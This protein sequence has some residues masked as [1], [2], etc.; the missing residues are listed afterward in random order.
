MIC[1]PQDRGRPLIRP[2]LYRI[3]AAAKAEPLVGSFSCVSRRYIRV[4]IA[5][6]DTGV[7]D[8]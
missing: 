1:P 7:V 2:L 3:A 8:R 5:M 6:G 4:D